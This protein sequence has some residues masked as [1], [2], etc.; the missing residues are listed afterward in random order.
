MRSRWAPRQ[1][2]QVARELLIVA[3]R[4]LRQLPR[5]SATIRDQLHRAAESVLLDTG[6]GAARRASKE[7]AHHFDVARGSAAEC[8]TA[9]DIIAIRRLAAQ[10]DVERARR[11]TP[12]MA[13]CGRRQRAPADATCLLS[14][15][16]RSARARAP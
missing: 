12:C 4:I 3:D 2:P 5:G 13:P 16:A 6:E 11:H 8:A 7:K 10:G 14:G 15:L 1:A 9:L